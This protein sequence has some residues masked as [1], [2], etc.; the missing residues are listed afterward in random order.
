MKI[1]ITG[2][3]GYIGARL[4]QY[5]SAKAHDII[6]VCYPLIPKVDYWCR[7]FY[8]VMCGDIRKQKTIE[9]IADLKADAIIHLISLDHYDSEKDLHFVSEINVLPTWNLLKECTKTGLKKFIYFSTIHVYGNLDDAII[10]DENHPIKTGNTYG[11]THYLSENICD[12]YNRNSNTN[13]ITVRLSN[14]YGAPIFP[15]NNCWWLVINDLCKSAYIN[16]HIKL[17]SD[18]SPQRDFIHGNDLCQ[19]VE[20]LIKLDNKNIQ[21]AIYHISSGNTQ[22]I[23]ELAE[24]IRTIYKNRYGETIPVSTSAKAEVEDFNISCKTQRY[25]IDNSRLRNIGFDPAWSFD[26]GI[27]ELFEYMEKNYGA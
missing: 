27:N 7:N 6:A 16:K 17:V 13:V 11:L 24:K 15:E 2:A 9:Q 5:L 12:H 14:S 10:I 8:K 4:C 23:L 21:K 22:T 1:I 20:L 25:V 3:N 18:G 19:A 26:K